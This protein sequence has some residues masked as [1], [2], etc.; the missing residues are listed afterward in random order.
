MKIEKDGIFY[1]LDADSCDP[2][3]RILPSCNLQ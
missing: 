1:E 3:V 2:V